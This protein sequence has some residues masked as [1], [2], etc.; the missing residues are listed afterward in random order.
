MN[1]WLGIVARELNEASHTA[2]YSYYKKRKK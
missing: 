2:I 1:W